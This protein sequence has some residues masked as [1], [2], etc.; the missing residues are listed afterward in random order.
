MGLM[1]VV[2]FGSVVLAAGIVSISLTSRGDDSPE[3]CAWEIDYDLTGQVQISE[4]LMGAGDGTYPIG[5]GSATFRFEDRGGKPGGHANLLEYKMRESVTVKA[6]T[7]AW[8]TT[9]TNETIT[10][11]TPDRCSI[12]AEGTLD[13]QTLRW[14]T[15][16]RGLHTDG[17]VTCTGYFCGTFGAPP[18]GQSEMHLTARPV[19]FSAL[20]FSQDMKTFTMP[21]THTSK[22]RSPKQ[23]SAISLSGREPKRACVPIA[24]CRR[25]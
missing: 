17:R 4:T 15:P 13:A 9:V 25:W 21:M 7:L 12:A 22:T 5:P 19:Q 6:K 16:I 24:P 23:S 8:T 14:S 3:P 20:T 2:R 18:A 11:A 1:R 10:S